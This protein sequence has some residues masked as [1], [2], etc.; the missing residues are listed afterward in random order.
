MRK[1]LST[2]FLLAFALQTEAQQIDPT[3]NRGIYLADFNGSVFHANFDGSNL[4]SRISS[5]I[6]NPEG[7]VY[8]P[9]GQLFWTDSE[10]NRL[11]TGTDTEGIGRALSIEGVQ[12]PQGLAL[13]S[14]GR[15]IYWVDNEA[16]HIRRANFD[17]SQVETLVETNASD[18]PYGIALDIARGKMYWTNRGSHN[19]LR[20]NLDGSQIEVVVTIG[21]TVAPFGITLDLTQD[22]LYWT[23][24]HPVN[25]VRRANLDGSGIELVRSSGSLRMSS[26]ISIDFNTNKLYWAEF[27][28]GISPMNPG[29]S[30]L[31]RANLDGSEIELTQIYSEAFVRGLDFNE[32]EGRMALGVSFYNASSFIRTRLTTGGD[33]RVIKNSEPHYIALDSLRG[34]MYWTNFLRGDIQR[35]NLD[36]SQCETIVPDTASLPFGAGIAVDAVAGK[37]YWGQTYPNRIRRANLDGTN[38]EDIV[39]GNDN[40]LQFSHSSISIDTV[41][42]KIYWSEPSQANGLI[43]RA[44]LDGQHIETII[45]DKKC[46]GLV[47]NGN[48]GKL[49]WFDGNFLKRSNLNGSGTESLFD[50][51][52][53]AYGY[54]PSLDLGTG[55]L[56]WIDLASSSVYRC[57]LDGSNAEIVMDL[58]GGT[59]RG[60]ALNTAPNLIASLPA[61]RAIDARQ[62]FAPNAPKNSFGWDFVDLQFD[63]QLL[64]ALTADHFS[65]SEIGGDGNPAILSGVSPLTLQSVRLHFSSSLEPGSWTCINYLAMGSE[66]CLGYLPGDVNGDGTASPM[67]ILALIN[68]LN[69]VQPRPVYATDIDR[70]EVT[71]SA[72]ILRLIDLLNG[73]GAFDSWNGVSLPALP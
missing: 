50:P 20:A 33:L 28:D 14:I 53:N 11:A 2:A 41:G 71:A 57:N 36:G 8:G 70:S 10:T 40:G 66:V 22:K 5:T 32:A 21:G 37:V 54:S 29:Q 68:S 55:K 46:R 45:T 18:N 73:A 56:Y 15:K 69:A 19:I 64:E 16:N 9:E 1:S 49:Y 65:I 13:D 25:R 43:R 4:E 59:S 58:P 60:L 6:D 63:G 44:D 52:G 72:D 47:V 24:A 17:G 31:R 3:Q 34:K 7:V 51:P 23:E 67:D 38:V 12:N 61:D 30:E 62:P 48:A 26:A 27:L 42:S 39:I 35:A